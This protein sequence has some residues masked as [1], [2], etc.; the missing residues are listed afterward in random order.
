MHGIPLS[1]FDNRLLW[2]KY[3]YRDFGIIAEPY[4]DIDFDEVLYL[5]DTG[6]IL[7]FGGCKLQRGQ[8]IIK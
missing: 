7:H 2:A 5:T 4:F 8:R 6:K 1:K 3:D